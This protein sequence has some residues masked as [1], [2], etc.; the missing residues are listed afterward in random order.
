MNEESN[1]KTIQT[2]LTLII[3]Y[4]ADGL[5]RFRNTRLQTDCEL[6]REKYGPGRLEPNLVQATWTGLLNKEDEPPEQWAT[7]FTVIW[8]TPAPRFPRQVLTY[9]SE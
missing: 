9:Q 8:L 4:A 3:K 1:T 7:C 2:L 5:L 6:T